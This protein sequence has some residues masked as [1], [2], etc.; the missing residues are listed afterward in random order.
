MKEY[1]RKRE[2]LRK[3][4]VFLITFLASALLFLALALPVTAEKSSTIVEEWSSVKAPPP[5]E[6]KPVALDP[7][8]TALLILD[9]QKQ[10]CNKD[11]RPRC[12]LSVP[13]IQSLLARARSKG[14]SVIYSL[15]TEGK[16]EDIIKELAPLGDEPIVKASV[17]KF[18][19]TELEKI[20]KEKK[21]KTLI[22]TGTVAH[23][24]VLHTATSAALRGYLVIIPVDGMSAED[25]YAEQYTAWHMINA[26][27][28]RKQATLTSIELINF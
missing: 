20:L 3:W 27:G 8:T 25:A 7:K 17:D 26:P 12:V 10:S 11:R 28:S 1:P 23:G 6:L 2:A 15:T 21:L 24:A 18:Y 13:K 4:F 16:P 19:G 14:M 9:I 5:P 22:V